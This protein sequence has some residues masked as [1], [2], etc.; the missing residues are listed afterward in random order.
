[1]HQVSVVLYEDDDSPRFICTCKMFR[2]SGYLCSH[3]LAARHVHPSRTIDLLAMAAKFKEHKAVGRKRSNKGALNVPDDHTAKLVIKVAR[4]GDLTPIGKEVALCGRSV[5]TK[6]GV[7]GKIQGYDQDT[8][9]YMIESGEA[10]CKTQSEWTEAEV[11][12]GFK[13]FEG[14]L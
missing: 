3:S 8:G 9:M 10:H 11:R 4:I 1:M 14:R 2:Q 6:A 5:A 12:D 7:M 13:E